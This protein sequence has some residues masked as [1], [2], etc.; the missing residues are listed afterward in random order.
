MKKKVLIITL[1]FPYPLTHGGAIAQYYFLEGLRDQFDFSICTIVN[2]QEELESIERFK[3][4]LPGVKVFYV[5]N[6]PVRPPVVK[7]SFKVRAA[8]AVYGQ[9]Q[10]WK[11]RGQQVEK[12]SSKAGMIHD[13]FLLPGM[14]NISYVFPSAFVDLIHQV[15][16]TEGIE[17][18]QSELY[19]SLS[20]LK[21]LPE[22][23]KKIFVHHELR[24]KRLETSQG[25][26]SLSRGFTNY[27]IENIRTFEIN[28]L[29][30]L[31][32][33]VVFNSKDQEELA[34]HLDNVVLS[35]FGVPGS[36][37]FKKAVSNKFDRFIFIG[38]EAH[39]PNA[40]GL[41]WFLDTIYVP[42][43]GKIDF[44][45]Y[46]IGEW[47][48]ATIAK[49]AA[50]GKINFTGKVDVLDD[51]Y[52]NS[53]ML[54]PI[55]AGSGL[56]TKILHAFANKMPVFSTALG[57]EDLIGHAE[58]HM[59]LFASEADFMQLY[60]EYCGHN[61][62]ITELALKGYAYFEKR[63]DSSRLIGMRREVYD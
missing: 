2:T 63:F 42:S 57:G 44:P 59:E 22:G 31:D 51:Y 13:D 24:Y 21:A 60:H 32:K 26:S 8:R 58:D 27:V 15:I 30:S 16:E 38:K 47:S 11:S 45:I 41:F 49:Y 29:K 9:Y 40:D 6:I 46:I 4:D 5:N 28:S 56:R 1:S 3:R 37:I 53:I 23:V 36:L 62:K 7:A 17:Y 18:V 20:A 10:K 12:A 54:V 19:E 25:S 50:C 14:I 34:T 33:V 43:A 48:E 52:E 61:E 55:L 39:T 35:P